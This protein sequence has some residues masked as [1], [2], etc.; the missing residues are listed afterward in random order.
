[1]YIKY[2]KSAQNFSNENEVKRQFTRNRYRYV[3]VTKNVL[4]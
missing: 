4:K 3:D 1:M 2:D